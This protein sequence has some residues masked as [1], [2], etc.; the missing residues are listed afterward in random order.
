MQKGLGLFMMPLR[1]PDI[2]RDAVT[3]WRAHEH[4]VS[5]ICDVFVLYAHFENDNR[6]GMLPL[7]SLRRDLIDGNV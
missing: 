2:K 3:A 4:F 6:S 7:C 1:Y 5:H